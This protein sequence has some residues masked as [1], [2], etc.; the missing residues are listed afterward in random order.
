MLV[1]ILIQAIIRFSLTAALLYFVY[2]E[3]GPLTVI[4]LAL[5]AIVIEGI[6][7]TLRQHLEIIK[8]MAGYDKIKE[9]K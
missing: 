1:K 9:K 4:Y 3:T 2:F 6:T 8:Q 7:L 5:T